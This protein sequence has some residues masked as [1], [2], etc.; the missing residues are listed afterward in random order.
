MT[1][2]SPS[3]SLK[4]KEVDKMCQEISGTTFT[5]GTQFHEK[6][7]SNI[8]GKVRPIDKGTKPQSKFIPYQKTEEFKTQSE[9]IPNQRALDKELIE[10][11]HL[12]SI[13]KAL[14]TI[15]LDNR[16]IVD[17]LNSEYKVKLLPQVFVGEAVMFELLNQSYELPTAHSIETKYK[18]LISV[19]QKA[20]EDYSHTEKSPL[21]IDDPLD[22]LWDRNDDPHSLKTIEPDISEINI[23]DKL[24]ERPGDPIEKQAGNSPQPIKKETDLTSL[25]GNPKISEEKLGEAIKV[26]NKKKQNFVPKKP[27]PI[28]WK[29]YTV[30]ING[31]K[32]NE[33]EWNSKEKKL[34]EEHVLK[35][36]LPIIKKRKKSIKKIIRS[37]NTW[38][39][40]V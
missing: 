23:L 2:K 21:T 35:Q 25:W 36:A 37:G 39:F 3:R 22:V 9:F 14:E 18:R 1:K 8:V 4:K 24:W 17:F 7:P 11:D 40:V 27:E 16:K 33:F 26:F 30:Q 29:N 6:F 31:K 12:N 5:T 38:N 13:K 32:I 10:N 19:V 20:F 28:V 34:L 15:Q